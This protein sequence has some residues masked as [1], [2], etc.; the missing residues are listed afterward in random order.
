MP[1]SPHAQRVPDAVHSPPASRTQRACQS[2]ISIICLGNTFNLVQ[3]PC[4]S[5]VVHPR[6]ATWIQIQ[7]AGW[8]NESSEGALLYRT[9][10]DL[11]FRRTAHELHAR[12]PRLGWLC[13]RLPSA[14]RRG[15]EVSQFIRLLTG[16]QVIKIIML[17]FR[18]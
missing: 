3:S 1:T 5:R 18:I 15:L 11:Q 14:R 6:P 8:R 7:L 12:E 17:Y 2:L 4:W 9:R 13:F 16:T 10:H